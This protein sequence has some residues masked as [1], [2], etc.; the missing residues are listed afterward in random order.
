MDR[1]DLHP[2]PGARLCRQTCRVTRRNPETVWQRSGMECH[3]G[4]V[5]H[6]A[7]SAS[8]QP[9]RPD[10]RGIA[11]LAADRASGLPPTRI[12]NRRGGTLA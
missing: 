8:P 12:A 3:P 2:D 5:R 7:N 4:L 11:A 1:I 10:F 6:V 9:F